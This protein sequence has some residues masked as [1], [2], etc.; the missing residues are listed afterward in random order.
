MLG[1]TH[2]LFNDLHDHKLALGTIRIVINID[3]NDCK[4]K[5]LIFFISCVHQVILIVDFCIRAV[6]SFDCF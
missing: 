4:L 1:P 5:L 2:C 3:R 6:R